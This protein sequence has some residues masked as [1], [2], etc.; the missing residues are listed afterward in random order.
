MLRDFIKTSMEKKNTVMF[1]TSLVFITGIASYFNN[2]E[3]A[4]AIML[5][6]VSVGLIWANK[7]SY[8]LGILW[9]IVFYLGV[10]QCALSYS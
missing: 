2:S 6:L 4:L 8:R 3:F 5:T 10:F 7:L 1:I 9:I